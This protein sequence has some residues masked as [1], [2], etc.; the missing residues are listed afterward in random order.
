[1][2]RQNREARMDRVCGTVTRIDEMRQPQTELPNL[3]T[4]EDLS[5]GRNQYINWTP[6]ALFLPHPHPTM[7]PVM[8]SFS[9]PYTRQGDDISI[10]HARQKILLLEQQHRNAGIPLSGR[11]IHVC[12]YLPITPNII[13]KN[14]TGIGVLSPPATPPIKD[15]DVLLDDTTPSEPSGPT[16]GCWTP[17][18]SLSSCP[19]IWSFSPRYGHSAM[20]SGI[21]SLSHT[22]EQLIV[23]WTGDI[24]SFED[25]VPVDTISADDRASFQDALNGYVPDSDDEQDS[26][27]KYVPVW[28]DDKVAHGHYDGYCKQSKLHQS[29]SFIH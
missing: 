15:A 9:E 4:N 11:I 20:T 27:V 24:M 14:S 22:H 29:N 21:R 5:R 26:E 28:L 7:P 19:S 12:H 25:K 23:G 6:T 13:S 17:P 8:D 18:S 1:M 16:T 2:A 3:D 10:E